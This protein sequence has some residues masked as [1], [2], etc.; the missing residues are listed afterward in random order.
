MGG[1]LPAWILR[2][3]V[4]RAL[5]SLVAWGGWVLRSVLQTAA[6]HRLLLAGMLALAVRIHVGWFYARG[7]HV[8]LAKRTAGVGYNYVGGDGSR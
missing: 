3:A 8:E 2:V 7:K 1:M 6:R 5:A 4:G